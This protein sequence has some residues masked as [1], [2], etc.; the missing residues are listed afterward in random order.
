MVA[1]FTASIT[2]KKDYLPQYTQI[3]SLLN[4]FGVEVI[5]DHIIKTHSHEIKAESRDTRLAF[6]GKLNHWITKSNFVVAEVSFPSTSVGFEISL[7]LQKGKPVL[8]LYSTIHP[9][10]LLADYKDDKCICEHYTE[11]NLKDTLENFL[12][13]VCD[14]DDCRFTLFLSSN[15]NEYLEKASRRKK[16]PKSVYLRRL[17]EKDMATHHQQ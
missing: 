15:M 17:I 16:Q 6:Q 11:H 1:Y 9:P 12:N 2:G 4:N 3:I 5:S 10:S 8:L 14:T 7:A 13:F